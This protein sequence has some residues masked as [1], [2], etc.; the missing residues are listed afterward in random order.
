MFPKCYIYYCLIYW[1]KIHLWSWLAQNLGKEKPKFSKKKYKGKSRE[2]NLLEKEASHQR[3]NY[4]KY[5]KLNKALPK[6]NTRVILDNP[7]ESDS[8]SSSEDDN[9][10]DEGRKK[11]MTYDSELGNSDKSSNSATNT[12]EESWNNGCRDGFFINKLNNSK[13]NI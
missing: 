3:A 4:L 10:P 6:K 11:S 7:Q 12:K 8:S 2:V 1:W 13:Y 9:S 5:K